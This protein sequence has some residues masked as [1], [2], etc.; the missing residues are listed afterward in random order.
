MEQFEHTEDYSYGVINIAGASTAF[1]SMNPKDVTRGTT[2][3]EKTSGS[4]PISYWGEENDFPQLVIADVR[5]NTKL[6]TLLDLK[7]KLLYSGGLMFGTITP[8]PNGQESMAPLDATRHAKIKDFFRKT[9]INRYLI[10]ASKDLYYFR[11]VFPEIILNRERSEILQLAVVAAEQCRYAKQNPS[12]GLIDKCYISAN[13]PSAKETD[14]LTK[15]LPV[16]DPYYDPSA[17]LMATKGSTNYIYP[18]SYPSPGNVYYQ[19]A[20]WNSIRESG[21][22]DV[23]KAI[24]K[25]KKALLEN[26]LTI[27]YH[28][29]I[30]NQYWEWKYSNWSTL[31]AEDRIKIKEAE[32][33]KFSDVM[34]GI[35]KS[36]NSFYSSF[37][38]D[39]TTGKDYPGWKITAIDDKIKDGKFIEDGKESS[40]YIDAAVGV[41]P[42]LTGMT[43]NSGLGG[44]GSNIREA[45]NL[46]VLTS[47]SEQDM[48]LEPLY[49]IRDFNKW[50]PDVEFRFKNSFMTTLD[51][52]KETTPT[53]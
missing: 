1:T 15:E 28:I 17:T 42:A 47:T 41:H 46:H 10:E 13:W 26:Q 40:S 29:E 25:F 53:N 12:T 7:A 50:G 27:K 21:W 20:D 48:I 38:S 51:K 44:A 37:K 11:N 31:K 3:V 30:S 5:T 35:E 16:L 14:S 39:P 23:A 24:P 36:G 34:S 22:L 32:M 45:Y 18:L 49:L 52:G 6:G 43:T 19:L 2:A 33:K 9:N 8:G 4:S